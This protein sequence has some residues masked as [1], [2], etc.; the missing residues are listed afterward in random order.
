MLD[1]KKIVLV[2]M[3][4]NGSFLFSE[5]DNFRLATKDYEVMGKDGKMYFLYFSHWE[6]YHYRTTNKRTGEELKKPVKEL[7]NPNA[8]SIDTCYCGKDG[9]CYR[10][11]KLEK[12]I[13]DLNLL[14]NSKGIKQALYI[15]TGENYEIEIV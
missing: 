12:E 2:R 7:V 15:I 5:I 4:G 11:A 8:L 6:R 1:E 3:G 14:Y 13:S 9:F 10:N